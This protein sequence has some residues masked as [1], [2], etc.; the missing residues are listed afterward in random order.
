MM[1]LVVPEPKNDNEFEDEQPSSEFVLCEL[2][3][4]HVLRLEPHKA[5]CGLPCEGGKIYLDDEVTH[6]PECPR[7]IG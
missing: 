6:D 2:C 5:A 1:M 3:G 7:C 4:Q